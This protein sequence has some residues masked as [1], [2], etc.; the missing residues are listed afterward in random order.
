M[1]PCIPV[2]RYGAVVAA[3]LVI[4]KLMFFRYVTVQVKRE[5][6]KAKTPISEFHPDGVSY[7]MDISSDNVEAMTDAQ[8][9]LDRQIIREDAQPSNAP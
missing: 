6:F 1:V 3:R 2:Y 7:W 8:R 4:K 5:Q 9:F